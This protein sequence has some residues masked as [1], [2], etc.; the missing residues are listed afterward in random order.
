M[1][2]LLGLTR[3]H[4]I[5]SWVEV[6]SVCTGAQRQG[7]R[8]GEGEEQGR[9]STSEA[10]HR[11]AGR[12]QQLRSPGVGCM[13][14]KGRRN[15]RSWKFLLPMPWAQAGQRGRSHRTSTAGTTAG[16]LLWPD[17][18]PREDKGTRA[19]RVSFQGPGRQGGSREASQAVVSREVMSV[20]EATFVPGDCAKAGPS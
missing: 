6:L 8:Q 19:L 15:H 7:R 13:L 16:I 9:G 20:R 5:L 12:S 11:P 17:A 10:G 18:I 4:L 3:G 14:G 1:A 2:V